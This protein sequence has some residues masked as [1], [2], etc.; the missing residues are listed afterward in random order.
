MAKTDLDSFS[1]EEHAALRDNATD[2]KS[3][4]KQS[5]QVKEQTLR[6]RGL[7]PTL[8]NYPERTEVAIRL[9]VPI[10]GAA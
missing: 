7:R 5:N 4:E 1:I 3:D 10:M 6:K 8:M 2:K 9:A